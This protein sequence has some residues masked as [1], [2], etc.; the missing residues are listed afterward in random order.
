M[1]ITGLYGF[2]IHIKL[3]MACY[4]NDKH[5]YLQT[6]RKSYISIYYWPTYI[7]SESWSGSFAYEDLTI[8]DNT[9]NYKA[10]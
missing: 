5:N 2:I 9:K 6:L 4:C 7:A 10:T 3:E 8:Y 1:S